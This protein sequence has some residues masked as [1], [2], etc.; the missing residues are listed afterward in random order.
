MKILGVKFLNLNSLRGEQE[1]RFDQPPFSDSGLFAITGPTGAGKTTILDA[2]TVGLYG[3]V[4]R[5]GDRDIAE[6]MSRHTAE[7]YS[8][9]EF[10]VKGVAYR[11]KWSLRRSRGKI[12][13]NLQGEK[14]EL[15]Q[16]DSGAFLGGHTTTSVKQ[17]IIEACGLDY[18]Q[19][20]RS[21]LLAQG[22][23]TRFLK[24]GD[25]DRSELLEKITDTGIYSE[26]SR[27]VFE[28]Q[29]GEKERLDGLKTRLESVELLPTAQR[30]AFENQ[31]QE[32]A[33]RERKVKEVQVQTAEKV[34]W[35]GSI[36][37]LRKRMDSIKEE[38]QGHQNSWNASQ[39]DFRRLEQHNKALSFKP[40]LSEIQIMQSRL[41]QLKV[42]LDQRNDELP[43]LKQEEETGKTE[44]EETLKKMESAQLA[45]SE[46]EPRLEKALLLDSALEDL[47]DRV[48]R[49]RL[50]WQQEVSEINSLKKE[51]SAKKENLNA[52]CHDLYSQEAWLDDHKH[53]ESL[54]QKLVVFRQH[55]REV[56]ELER[57][58]EVTGSERSSLTKKRLD[59]NNMLS[60]KGE[61]L[62]KLKDEILSYGSSLDRYE[63]R[64][65]QLLG[66][67]SPEELE[68][69]LSHL[70]SL[71]SNCEQ[72]YKLAGQ[73]RLLIAEQTTL[74]EEIRE[75][76][77]KLDTEE[78]LLSKLQKE[79]E[80]AE[81]NLRDLRQLVELQQR[82]RK[83]ESDRSQL[84]EGDPCPL[85]GSVHHPYSAGKV[86][87][88]V[89]DAE[90]K[91]DLQE[92]NVQRLIN[93]VQQKSMVV[94][95]C[96][97]EIRSKKQLLE[98]AEADLQSVME[99]FTFN[100]KLLPAPLD[101]GNVGVIQAVKEKKKN[102]LAGLQKMIA[103]IRQLKDHIIDTGNQTKRKQEQLSQI[104]LD[105]AVLLQR[106]DVVD[107]EIAKHGEQMA[108]LHERCQQVQTTIKELLEPYNL[109]FAIQELGKT[110][111]LLEEMSDRYDASLN[112]LQQLKLQKVQVETE[113]GKSEE[114][115]DEKE[116]RLKDRD[117]EIKGVEERFRNT[118]KE[119]RLL[120]GDIVPS[121]ERERLNK[122]VREASLQKEETYSLWQQKKE[123]VQECQTRC[124]QIHANIKKDSTALTALQTKL[125]KTLAEQQIASVHALQALFLQEDEAQ[126]IARKERD[127]E[128]KIAG[129]TRMRD[130]IQSELDREVSRQ[131]TSETIDELQN[132]VNELDGQIQELNQQIGQLKNVLAE[133]DRLKLKYAEVSGLIEQQ[134]KEFSR[135]QKLSALIGSADGKKF[136]RFAQGLTLARLT[137]LAN[138]HLTKLTD[139]YKILKSKEKDLELLIVDSYQA[140]AVRPMATL[141][142]GESFLVSLAMALG[143]SD[144]AS[145][146]V[147]INSLF[148]DEGFGTLDSET[149]DVAI[150]ALENLQAG[151]KNIGIISHV[152][153]LKE[154]ISTQIQLIKQPGGSSRIHIV[155]LPAF[156]S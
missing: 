135:W 144:L 149:L 86:H 111:R 99:E 122:A 37:G 21:V 5:L 40:A 87:D 32:L 19:F 68:S 104:E 118:E 31:L 107:D 103:E 8:E 153:A 17:A 70:P 14:M 72:Q 116:K 24:A 146:K 71:I 15:A 22:E 128:T 108:S 156:W 129:L 121:E 57:I 47:K 101:I 58:L 117:A 46:A 79:K 130:S 66:N 34:N 25:N 12:D 95:T 141:S 65:G 2:I 61:E 51:L 64:L 74:R 11:A 62:D 63:Q 60:R 83:Y 36:S 89:P 73:Y 43:R 77:R 41:D 18:N 39:N 139:R 1:I 88:E 53:Y 23:F 151:G 100:N 78:V 82:I 136:S 127:L 133:D 9:V 155:G 6:I 84:R 76:A 10:E 93:E 59:F 140:D 148:I 54:D 105:I 80:D 110:G 137:A 147:Q 35:L 102:E 92:R 125:E 85:C 123:K 75:E 124:E 48:A 94:N 106:Q 152:D 67:M 132:R 55:A 112:R 154:R 52:V 28:R 29:K 33:D 49:L 98:K 44:V 113:T 45:L 4:P 7:C 90:K 13:G 131:L 50:S 138:R 145:R 91:R 120:L 38:L 96:Q 97:H 16:L 20:L 42:E 150:S 81:S 56:S 26:V 27:Y 143:L 69:Q 142:G 30:L 119:R 134:Q 3:R 114:L 109:N 115:L 126:R